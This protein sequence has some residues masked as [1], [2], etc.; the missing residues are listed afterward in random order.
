M[1]TQVEVIGTKYDIYVPNVDD[2]IDLGYTHIRV[3]QEASESVAVGAAD[4]SILLVAGTYDY[5]YNK[6]TGLQTDWAEHCFYSV[7]NGEGPHTERVPL[8]RP[9]T[10][11]LV[12][13]QGVGRKLRMMELFTVASAASATN[14]I[15]SA[16]IDPDASTQ[17]YANWF[18][19][20]ASGTYATAIRRVRGAGTGYVVATGEIVVS[21]T[22]GGSLVLGDTVEL[23]RPHGDEDPSSIIDEAI[24]DARVQMFLDETWIFSV[25]S[26]VTEY[27]MPDGCLE[28]TIQ[29]VEWAAGTYPDDPEWIELHN[30]DTTGRL[31]SVGRRT[32]GDLI[33]ISYTPNPDILDSDSD[34]WECD[35]QWAIAEAALAYLNRIGKPGGQEEAIEHDRKR[36]RLMD[37][38]RL[39]RPR[40]M[41]MARPKVLDPR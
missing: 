20:V 38:L 27:T 30:Y 35:K 26:N 11:R 9:R 15:A 8:D 32:A 39:L 1:S 13:R 40:Y 23:W 7:A 12:I 18:A 10:T 4:T 3:F 36:G 17:R 22:Y 31:I 19:R 21:R 24:N 29:K 28:Q 5:S 41:P 37:E 16:L 14:F 2:L 34:Y 6:T 33:R 25:D